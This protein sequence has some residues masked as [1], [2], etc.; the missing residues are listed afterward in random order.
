MT[1]RFMRKKGI[2]VWLKRP[3]RLKLFHQD[4][5]LFGKCSNETVGSSIVQQLCC[6]IGMDCQ[7]AVHITA[8]LM[9]K[10]KNALWRI[11]SFFVVPREEP[12]A[13][14]MEIANFGLFVNG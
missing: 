10:N 7:G 13:P 11:C 4:L 2:G 6:L 9:H 5:M 1:K 14:L 3:G 8:L 12:Q